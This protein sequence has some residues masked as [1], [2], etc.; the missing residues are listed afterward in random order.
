MAGDLA[1][2]NGKLTVM[3]AENT[4]ATV[5]MITDLN[6]QHDDSKK[7]YDDWY[8]S[9]VKDLVFTGGMGSGSFSG[10][11]VHMYNNDV[12]VVVVLVVVVLVVAWGV[13]V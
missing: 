8:N 7:I 5:A 9:N 6:T 4:D 3:K 11:S 13:F 1:K 12:L 2:L 10:G